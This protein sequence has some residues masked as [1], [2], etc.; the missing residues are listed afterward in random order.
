MGQQEGLQK[1]AAIANDQRSNEDNLD[2]FSD[3][4]KL[5]LQL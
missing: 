5:L 2:L 1:V 3:K 4:E